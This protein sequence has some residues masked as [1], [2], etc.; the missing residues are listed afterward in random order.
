[1]TKKAATSAPDGPLL[2]LDGMSLAFRAFFALPPEMKTKDGVVT[3][4][5]FGFM[6]MLSLLVR[7]HYPSGVAVAFDL[8]GPTFRDEIVT[9][10]KGGRDATPPELEPQ[11][12][13]I[14]DLL[15]A[16]AIPV[17]TQEGYEADDVLATLATRARDEGRDV[18]VVTGDRDCFQLVEDP[19]VRV[20]YN[21][22]GVSEYSLYDEAGIIERTGVEPRR[23]PLLAALRGDPSDNLPG[24]PGVGEKT[25]AKLLTQFADFEELFAGLGQLTPKLRAS[26]AEHE[27]LARRNAAVMVLV[28]DLD[29]AVNPAELTLGGWQRELGRAAFDAVEMRTQWARLEVLL[30]EG[31]F[32]RSG[33][34]ADVP[35][36]HESRLVGYK[37]ADNAAELVAGAVTR[38][39][40]LVVAASLEG[41]RIDRLVVADPGAETA[42]TLSVATDAGASVLRS[43]AGAL[44]TGHDLKPLWRAALAVGVDL[45][46]PAEDTAIAAYLLDSSS[47]R[48]RLEEVFTDV[49]GDVAPWVAASAQPTLMDD[50]DVA[51]EE[52]RERA[53]AIAAIAA[54]FAPRLAEPVQQALLGGMELPLLRVLAR[55]EDRGIRVDAGVLRG[56]AE[57]LRAEA[58]SLEAAIHTAV[59]HDFQINST[60]Q[61]QVVLY[62]ELGLTKGRKT[63]TGYSTD[64]ATLEA[65]RGEHDVVDMLLRFREV[66]KLRSTYGESLA[67][68]VREDGRIHA[69]FRQTVARTGRLSSEQPNLHNIP[70]RTE[71]GRRFRRAFLPAEGWSLLVADYDQIELRVIAHLSGDEGL[72][73]AFSG[74]RDVHR[75]IA[76]VVFAIAPEEVSHE[77]RERAKAVS[78]GLAYGMEAYGLARRFGTSVGEAKDLMDQYFEAFPGVRSFMDETVAKARVD[79]CTTTLFGRVRHLPELV[80]GTHAARAAAERQAMNAGTQGTAADIFKL[81]LVRL[82]DALAS[83]GLEARIVLHVHDEVLVEAPP[84]ETDAVTAVAVEA[85]EHVVDLRV[86]L[87]VS[88]GWGASWAE[89]K[90]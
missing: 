22:R 45:G 17:V 66:D 65:L 20:L 21:R 48:Y 79:G 59:G 49:T 23:Y 10:Y 26:L 83:E 62:D 4:A 72:R 12:G 75:F 34:P 60:K 88:Y 15:G 16:L 35:V 14:I 41:E 2:L 70:T 1:V 30:D 51:D 11:F 33:D 43:L 37:P 73:A 7:D 57:E 86:P 47:G 19:H 25:A 55:M 58:A 53:A 3:N 89:A 71:D 87:K 39:A 56:I 52:L 74:D 81:A 6:S 18:I 42:A 46:V 61:L 78:Y 50:P 67:A 85:L 80:E 27:E 29:L 63:K 24:V 84:A 5:A 36:V 28:R 69:T 82:D 68:E 54:T 31:L 76:G 77:Q 90:G 40:P 32:G 38:S 9:E 64:A 13:I 8:P 44:V